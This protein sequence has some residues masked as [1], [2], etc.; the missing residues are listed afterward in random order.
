MKLL[1]LNQR[2]LLHY[3]GI[4][5]FESK[6]NEEEGDRIES[7]GTCSSIAKN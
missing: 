2:T 6:K 5:V 4:R 7:V 1:M 3:I